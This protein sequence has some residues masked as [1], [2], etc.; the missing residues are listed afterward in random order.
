MK[1]KTF[2]GLC[3]V[4]CFFILFCIGYTILDIIQNIKEN[5]IIVSLP[6]EI[7]QAKKGDV[8]IVEKVSDSIYIGF[9]H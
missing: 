1:A 8:L 7:L 2:Y 3:I 9:K 5:I 6:E 4:I